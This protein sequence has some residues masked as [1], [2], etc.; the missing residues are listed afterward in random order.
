MYKQ[1]L[2]YVLAHFK[3]VTPGSVRVDAKL[4][5][6]DKSIIQYLAFKRPDKR[7]VAL[8]YNNSTQQA[9][10]LLVS[11]NPKKGIQITL[12]PKSLN[13]LIYL[14]EDDD[15][16]ASISSKH[17]DTTNIFIIPSIWS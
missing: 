17:S 11:E 8:L 6:A 7:I 1:P 5:G 15:D 14:N 2:F 3:F 10:D 13:T 9:I 12:K 4:W 16:G